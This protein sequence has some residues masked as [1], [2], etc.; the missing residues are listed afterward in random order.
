DNVARIW[1]VDPAKIIRELKHDKP[2]M[3]AWFNGD[4]T[5]ILTVSGETKESGLQG[6]A[7]VWDTA[8]G[9][10]L[11][12]KPLR[13]DDVLWHAMFDPSGG[14]VVRASREGPAIVWEVATG[15]AVAEFRHRGPVMFASFSADGQQVVTA[16]ADTT[17]R[18]WEAATGRPVGKPFSHGKSLAR[19]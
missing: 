13:H 16:S 12:G 3:K 18:V 7:R 5:R 15:K 9:R 19:A 8:T 10:E 4:G 14:G 11:S 6:E 1:D 2:V 17:A